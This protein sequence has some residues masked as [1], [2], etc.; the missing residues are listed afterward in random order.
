MVTGG[1]EHRALLKLLYLS[2]MLQQHLQNE[3]GITCPPARP[4]ARGS[5]WITVPPTNKAGDL[6]IS[7]ELSGATCV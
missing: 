3:S 1:G 4:P 2:D 6:K 5:E 7:S